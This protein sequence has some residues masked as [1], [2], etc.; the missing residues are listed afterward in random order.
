MEKMPSASYVPLYESTPTPSHHTSPMLEVL[1]QLQEDNRR[2]HQTVLDMQLRMDNSDALSH[3]HSLQL[4]PEH[5]P[6]VR[7]KQTVAVPQ[8]V[9][10]SVIEEEEE[11][12]R[13]PPPP[14]TSDEGPKQPN[15]EHRVI[16]VL[17]ELRERILKLELKRS[18]SPSTPNYQQPDDDTGQ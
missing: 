15:P 3:H 10:Q 6:S 17:E 5:S 12:W 13:P 4:V 7:M 16:D 9:H 8:S 18:S 1:Q 14:L 11:D 2:L